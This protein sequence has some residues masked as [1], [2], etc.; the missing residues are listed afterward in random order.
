[1][2]CNEGRG[3]RR[4]EPVAATRRSKRAAAAAAASLLEDTASSPAAFFGYSKA[5]AAAAVHGPRT[6]NS[7]AVG[8]GELGNGY[9]GAAGAEMM[10]EM[11]NAY[12]FSTTTGFKVRRSSVAVQP[13]SGIKAAGRSP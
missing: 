11:G 3:A 6:A 10:A 9:G 7:Q 1:M 2:E 8:F 4:E 5:A 12:A 13:T